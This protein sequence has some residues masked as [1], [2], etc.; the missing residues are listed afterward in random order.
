MA[1]IFSH[2]QWDIL[3]RKLQLGCKNAVSLWLGARL[4]YSHCLPLPST[5]DTWSVDYF[6]GKCETVVSPACWRYHSLTLSTEIIYCLWLYPLHSSMA[7]CWRYHSLTLSIEIIYWLWL[8]P[9]L[10][11]MAVCDDGLTTLLAL[12]AACWLWGW[13]WA[14]HIKHSFVNLSYWPHRKCHNSLNSCNIW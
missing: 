3:M 5:E 1:A 6:N 12:S 7:A 14:D 10:S 13:L 8:Y 2:P 9:L 4:W 11:S